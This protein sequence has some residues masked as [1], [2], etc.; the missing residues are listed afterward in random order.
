MDVVADADA[1]AAVTA[2]AAGSTLGQHNCNKTVNFYVNSSRYR[3]CTHFF[4][5]ILSSFC[6]NL[7]TAAC[8]F[9]I[10]AMLCV[11]RNAFF[12]IDDA[13]T[14]RYGPNTDEYYILY[15]PVSVRLY[16]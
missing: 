7:S 15:M 12:L 4:F 10:Y 8:C 5:D 14:Q 6:W 3:A 2:V 9:T 1:D 13:N 11:K 16:L